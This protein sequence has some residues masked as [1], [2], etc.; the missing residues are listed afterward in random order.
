MEITFFVCFLLFFYT[1]TYLRK[2]VREIKDVFNSLNENIIDNNLNNVISK[3]SSLNNTLTSIDNTLM[4][5]N[6][7]KKTQHVLRSGKT[8]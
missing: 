1:I 2:S 8:F 3:I 7:V 6:Q 5:V 4:T